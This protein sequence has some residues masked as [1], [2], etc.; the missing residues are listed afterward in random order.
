MITI[1][2]RTPL[3]LW[4]QVGNTRDQG[5][6]YRPDLKATAFKDALGQVRGIRRYGTGHAPLDEVRYG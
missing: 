2:R 6:R 3:W 5:S 4:E 1:P